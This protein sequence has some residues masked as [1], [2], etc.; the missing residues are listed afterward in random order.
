[1]ILVNE[2]LNKIKQIPVLNDINVKNG[3]FSG[4][5]SSS[6]VHY[7]LFPLLN[8]LGYNV[9]DPNEVKVS[10]G[11][12]ITV[13]YNGNKLIKIDLVDLNKI[14]DIEESKTEF[15]KTQL[16][17]NVIE[18][19]KIN[20]WTTG[21][22]YS[23]YAGKEKLFDFDIRTLET[24]NNEL[25]LKMIAKDS[26]ITSIDNS[27]YFNELVIES[28]FGNLRG[29]SYVKDAL[30]SLLLNPNSEL[31]SLLANGIYET[32]CEKMDINLLKSKLIDE[33]KQHSVNL[34]DILLE[35]PIEEVNVKERLNNVFK[36]IDE[37]EIV[38]PEKPSV[39]PYLTLDDV[40]IKEVE[41]NNNDVA[42]DSHVDDLEKLL[43]KDD[44]LSLL[45]SED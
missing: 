28:K 38:I 44:D 14:K 18:G 19:S 42:E 11:K 41:I 45:L 13:F 40:D 24:I 33:F 17:I 1:M 39:D 37:V 3:N 12:C 15:E 16:A 31:I 5:D 29:T 23:L 26:L 4:I 9:F 2:I 30:E 20:L 32:H 35:K 27:K 43:D 25:L 36:N 10:D 34:M 21:I 6:S 8:S 7:V 22:H